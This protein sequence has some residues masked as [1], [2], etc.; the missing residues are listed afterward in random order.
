MNVSEEL[1][2]SFMFPVNKS[3]LGQRDHPI[4]ARQRDRDAICGAF[5]GLRGGSR[6][7]IIV[8]AKG[9]ELQGTVRRSQTKGNVYVQFNS[10]DPEV[11]NGLILKDKVQVE[12]RT[13]QGRI[14]LHLVKI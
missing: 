5:S 8:N 12:L 2:A 6:K 3:F 1:I 10:V 4:T 9:V 13:G 11:T 14:E 7:L